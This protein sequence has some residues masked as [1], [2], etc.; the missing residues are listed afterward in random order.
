MMRWNKDIKGAKVMMNE[1]RDNLRR[2]TP[3]LC[4]L[5]NQRNNEERSW[6]LLGTFRD[7]F[8]HNTQPLQCI[9]HNVPLLV[10]Q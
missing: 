6:E 4:G 2:I 8:K 3:S 9:I 10:T 7:C 1:G 5:V